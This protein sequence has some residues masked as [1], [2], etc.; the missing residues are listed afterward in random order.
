M[1]LFGLL[2]LFWIISNIFQG[3]GLPFDAW[4]SQRYYAAK[5]ER[6]SA[7]VAAQWIVLFS[8]R[9]LLMMGVGILALGIAE[10]ISDPEIALPA[11]IDHYVPVVM[12]GL[13][14]S[15]LIAA[16]MSTIDSFVNAS[17]AYFV[18]D[19]YKTYLK[20][21]AGRQHLI[22]VSYATTAIIIILGIILGWNIPN[23]N[24]IWGWM[25]MGLFTGMLPPNILKWFWW[26]FN[27]MGYAFGM[28]A[29]ILAAVS[30]QL[31]FGWAPEY[32][33]FS[34]VILVSTV[35]TVLGVFLGK[36]TD[37]AVLIHFYKKTKPF[38][39]W[40]P[41]RNACES[42]FVVEV[43]K[44]NL[45]DLLLLAPACVW[46]LTLFWVMTALVAEKWNAFWFSFAIVAGLS[47]VLYKYWY[48]NLKQT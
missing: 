43:R 17:A 13:L 6:E 28:G 16:G 26:R 44:E 37:M 31:A 35:G 34:F 25:V 30:H 29:G 10:K 2:V 33:T 8:L 27:G 38:G 9:F 3:F 32:M 39:C 46:Q 40:G 48:K 5:N 15:A 20:P 23:I 47:V 14:L 18:K 41:V 36:P 24:V 11:V 21:D 7:L 42:D 45:R 1:Q 4:T 12:K 19:I 22:K